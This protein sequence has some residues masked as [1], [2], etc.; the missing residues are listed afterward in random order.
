MNLNKY[1]FIDLTS[2]KNLDECKKVVKTAYKKIPKKY[3]EQFI[4]DIMVE[5]FKFGWHIGKNKYFKRIKG[6]PIVK[7][8]F[9]K[10]E[11]MPKD[12]EF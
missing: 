5:T 1:M 9:M 2:Y 12:N 6:Q 8:Q 10:F 4:D 3:M 7:G 11:D